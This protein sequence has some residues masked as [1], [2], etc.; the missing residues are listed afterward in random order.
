M[1]VHHRWKEICEG[2]LIINSTIFICE[3][4]GSP[5]WRTGRFP[6]FCSPDFL[7]R[8]EG[9]SCSWSCSAPATLTP[10]I[11]WQLKKR[12]HQGWKRAFFNISAWKIEYFWWYW[13]K[14]KCCPP[15][16]GFVHT[17]PAWWVP[18]G[19]ATSSQSTYWLHTPHQPALL[20]K[21]QNTEVKKYKIE[22]EK[23]QTHA[24]I[25]KL[26]G[27][28]SSLP[29]HILTAYTTPAGTLCCENTKIPQETKIQKGCKSSKKK[30][31]STV[32]ANPPTDYT[33]QHY[34]LK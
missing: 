31:G 33:S 16:G 28:T 8:L 24:K 11:T 1:E 17:G 3:L 4:I 23:I 25:Q 22:E 27:A 10:R 2:D 13:N 14:R 12:L 30:T 20:Q 5:I 15:T 34:I 32:S 26:G 6:P 29:I 7:R 18:P 9:K 21:I 19:G